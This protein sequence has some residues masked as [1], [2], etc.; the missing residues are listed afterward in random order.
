MIQRE[1]RAKAPRK[2]LC[3][4]SGACP[5]SR[6]PLHDIDQPTKPKTHKLS[7]QKRCTRKIEKIERGGRD[8]RVTTHGKKNLRAVWC[9]VRKREKD[10]QR[11]RE[12]ERETDREDERDVQRESKI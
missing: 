7:R 8:E 11:E 12:R 3:N 9:G 6:L 10:K 1:M 4:E 5:D 2:G